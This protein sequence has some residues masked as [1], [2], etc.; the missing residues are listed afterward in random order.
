MHR[1]LCMPNDADEIRSVSSPKSINPVITSEL[2]G[3]GS[4]TASLGAATE[5]QRIGSHSSSSVPGGGSGEDVIAT[6][7]PRHYFSGTFF[8]DSVAG[9]VLN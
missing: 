9:H 4:S 7:K 8:L 2:G 5:R 3:V 6:R 1:D